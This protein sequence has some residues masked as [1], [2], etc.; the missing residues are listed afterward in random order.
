M[1]KRSRAAWTKLVREWRESGLSGRAFA[2]RRGVG[3]KSLFW[4]SS[5]LKREAASESA[6]PMTFI[7]VASPTPVLLDSRLEIHLANGRWI[8]VPASFDP[9]ALARLLP[10]VEAAR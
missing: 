8:V 9:D 3:V 4:W 7:E 2:A 1:A 6:R 5:K 10:I